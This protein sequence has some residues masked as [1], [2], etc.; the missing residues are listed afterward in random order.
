MILGSE[1]E[2][3]GIFIRGLRRVIESLISHV[4][5]WNHPGL[6]T[7]LYSGACIPLLNWGG[8]G[9]GGGNHDFL[10]TGGLF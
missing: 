9:G 10:S 2:F 3:R 8:G 7:G 5:C 1:R 6:K 4:P